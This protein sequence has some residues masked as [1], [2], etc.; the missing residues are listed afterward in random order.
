MARIDNKEKH[1]KNTLLLLRTHKFLKKAHNFSSSDMLHHEFFEL[2]QIE[3]GLP[4][5]NSYQW[6]GHI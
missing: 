3:F 1:N 5:S 4:T 6:I 2:D